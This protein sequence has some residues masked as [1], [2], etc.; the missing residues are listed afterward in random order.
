MRATDA[1]LKRLKTDRIDLLQLHNIRMEQVEDDALW[2]TLEQ[3][4]RAG[5]VRSYGIA[6]GPAIGW[7]YEGINTIRE[8]GPTSV[9]H[10]YNL[11][12]QHPGRALHETAREM[13]K[14]T[15]FLI[16]VPHSSGMLEGKYTA[17]TVFPPGD[18]RA[19]RPR[20]WLL[21]GVKKIDQLRFLENTD[22]TLGQAAL[23]WLLADD[24]VASTLPNIYNEEQLIEFAKA[25]ET[26]ALTSDDMERIAELCS[27]NFGIEEDPPKFKGTMELAETAAV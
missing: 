8:R 10:I 6:L 26:P 2:K 11:L 21:N 16:R 18:H 9:Q 25:P 23:Q 22:R 17:E 12:E 19:H 27:D 13:N 1:A 14:D 20:S 3:L 5:K 4:Q 15:M 7:M 24:R